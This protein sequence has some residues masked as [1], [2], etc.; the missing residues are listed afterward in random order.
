MASRT[1]FPRATL[2]ISFDPRAL[3]ELPVMLASILPNSVMEIPRMRGGYLFCVLSCRPSGL[4]V[5]LPFTP[6]EALQVILF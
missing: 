4:G 6:V 2:K 3:Q 5:L 1:A